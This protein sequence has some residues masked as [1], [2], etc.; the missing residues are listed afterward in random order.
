MGLSF[1]PSSGWAAIN[2]ENTSLALCQLLTVLTSLG[3]DTSIER[4]IFD[5]SS[6]FATKRVT[7]T[8]GRFNK[9]WGE[10]NHRLFSVF[11]G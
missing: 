3:L 10:N 9:L 1:N 5:L 2:S 11:M 6:W 7:M 8:I 4:C